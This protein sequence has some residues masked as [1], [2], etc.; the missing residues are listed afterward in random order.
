LE[1]ISGHKFLEGTFEGKG[2]GD[3]GAAFRGMIY[4]EFYETLSNACYNEHFSV[5]TP[6]KRAFSDG[7]IRASSEGGRSVVGCPGEEAV[8]GLKKS[9]LVPLEMFSGLKKYT[10]GVFIVPFRVLSQKQYDRR[11]LTINFTCR[12][13]S[14]QSP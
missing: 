1:F 2:G 6:H 14:K 8:T 7:P 4:W 11:Y 10:A 9:G 5:D 13:N 12:R 3:R